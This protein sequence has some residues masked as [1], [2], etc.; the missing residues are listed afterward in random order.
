MKRHEANVV[1]NRYFG[2]PITNTDFTLA[3]IETAYAEGR[4]VGL[5]AQ[6]IALP[7]VKAA[8]LE[9][10]KPIVK[11]EAQK[12]EEYMTGWRKRVREEAGLPA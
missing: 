11:T 1:L 8:K 2:L 5:A 7:I 4:L 9:G 3:Q 10:P 12:H 6:K